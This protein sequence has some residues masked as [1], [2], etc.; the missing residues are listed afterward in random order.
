MRLLY[1]IPGWMSRT[2]AGGEELGRRLEFLRGAAGAGTEIDAWDV[3]GGPASIESMYEE[4]L[5]IPGALQRVQ[6]A[7]RVG[8]QGIILGCY[9]DP[10]VDA[11]R[12]LVRIP[13]VGPGEASMLFAAA[14]GHRFSILTV[15]DTILHPLRRLA[16]EVGVDGKLASVRAVGIPV[17]ELSQDRGTTYE[18][19]LEVGR[20]ARDV[21]GADTLVLGC[22]TMAFLN[23][24]RRL[25]EA[26]GIPVVNPV[27]AALRLLEAQ[28]MMGLAHSARAYP[29]PPKLAAMEAGAG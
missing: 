22:M 3:E 23:E 21:D 15:L 20:L 16:R 11:A 18:R 8:I 2:T 9:G 10:G 24:D 14:L 12:E 4:Y 1:L 27:H 17:L 7:A 6:E 5:S 25:S 26:L 29:T 28:V 19:M 13:V